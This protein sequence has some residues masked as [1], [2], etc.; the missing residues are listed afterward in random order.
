MGIEGNEIVG[1]FIDGTGTHGF[2]YD[3]AAF[4]LLDN[5]A[6]IATQPSSVSNGRIV[7]LYQNGQ[8]GFL[9]TPVL[10]VP[11]VAPTAM[12]GPDQS[13]RA[14][15]TVFLDGTASYDDNTP[16]DSLSYSWSFGTRPAGS[17]AILSGPNTAAPSFVADV[18][19]TYIFKLVVTDAGGLSSAPAFVTISSANLP[20]TAVATAAPALVIIGGSVTLNGTASTDPENDPL[21]YFWTIASAPAGSAATLSGATTATPSFVPNVAG[22]YAIMLTV[23]D[24]L[25]A[26]TPATAIVTATTA[27]GYANIVV[28]QTDAVIANLPPG[29]VTTAGN[30]NAL[31]NFLSQA[32]AALNSGNTA[33]AIAKLRAALERTDGCAIRGTPDLNGPGRDWITDS[34]AQAQ[35]YPA[36][37]S[38]LAA[39][40]P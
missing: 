34:A 33:L 4:S 8:K 18:A 36:L 12:A 10:P 29:Q 19:D 25:G 9:A 27:A 38:A 39:L 1:F 16:T 32:L 21:S 23:Y 26:G 35:I 40:T 31:S 6:G 20:P 3:G 17:T 2:R 11:N 15:V 30:Q 37:K 24:P 13:I 5:P 22:T 7:G 28:V 14:G